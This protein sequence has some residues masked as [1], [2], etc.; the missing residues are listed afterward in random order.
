M[1]NKRTNIWSAIAI[2]II[3]LLVLSGDSLVNSLVKESRKKEKKTIRSDVNLYYN[4]LP[5]LFIYDDIDL[6]YFKNNPEL[7][8]FDWTHK[9]PNNKKLIKMTYGLSVLYSPFFFAADIYASNSSYKTNGY[10]TPYQLSIYISALFYFII[11]LFL[12]RHLL[13]KYFKDPVV[14]ITLLAVTIGTNL[15]YFTVFEPGMPHV[16]NFFLIIAFLKLTIGWY[17][18]P[19]KRIT[20]LLGLTAGL[21]SLIRPTNTLI[22]FIFLLYGIHQNSNL[23]NHFRY[24]L[25]RWPDLLLMVFLAFL[26]WIPQ[27]I[28]WHTI[29]G[30][31]LFFSYANNESFFF[32]QPQILNI[33]FSYKK[34][35]LIYT[36]IM[37][38]ALIGLPMLRKRLPEFFWPM[39]LFF[40]L[41]IYILSCWWN[42]WY[43]GGFGLRSFIDFYG[44]LA[45]PFA[46]FTNF[47]MNKKYLKYIF[48]LFVVVLIL[49]NLFQSAQ[50][51]TGAIYWQWMNKKAYRETFLKL[52]PTPKFYHLLTKPVK[53]KAKKGE[54]IEIPLVNKAENGKE[55]RRKER[56]NALNKDFKNY[57]L[58]NTQVSDSLWNISKDSNEYKQHLNNYKKEHLSEFILTHRA[59]SLQALKQSIRQKPVLM[60]KIKKKAEKRDISTDSMLT[61][62]ALYLYKRGNR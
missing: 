16:F 49:F 29:S 8:K 47:M 56:I 19:T 30:N 21:I 3:I 57:I 2:I 58:N 1:K 18:K 51:K 4:Y 46:V 55:N 60:A 42:W 7:K 14:A 22:V 26:I 20:I 52:E 45:L 13:L 11:A 40:P 6:E 15:Y 59:E 10:S 53:E 38:F 24:L 27:M 23:K 41:I 62:D 33:L 61:I 32:G 25:N 43:G 31:W 5:A 36:P 50:Y 48:L 39:I 35:W 34:G 9:L 37:V 12:L 44:L 28:Y 54:Y 17:E